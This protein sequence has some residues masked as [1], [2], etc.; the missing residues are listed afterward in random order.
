MKLIKATDY[1]DMS[2]KAASIFAAQI[3]LKP[4]CVLGLATGSTPLGTYAQLINWYNDGDLDF[5]Q[6]KTVNL[7]EYVGLDGNNN[8][9]YRYF[10]ND[11]LFN[12]VNI[13]KANTN[14]P[15]GKA[16]DKQAECDRYEA[17]IKAL[18]GIDV[19]L[20]GI[21]NNGHIGFNEPNKYFD[22]G[23]HEV[24][25]TE[26]TITANARFFATM[27]EVPKTAISMGVQTIMQAKKIVLIA[28]GPAKADIIYET[29]FGPITPDVPASALQLHPDVTVIVDEEA[30]A[31]VAKKLGK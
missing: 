28:N 22:K 18:G 11:K 10:M 9:S 3:T 23:T 19:Q 2:K 17:L 26:S 30:Y 25:L 1:K 7:D 4:N 12:H 16:T 6:V 15:N 20:L 29:C 24:N 27:D 8:Q 13:D 14:V 31:T 21:G 5:S